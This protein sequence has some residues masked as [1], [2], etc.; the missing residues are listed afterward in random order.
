MRE[1]FENYLTEYD[2]PNEAKEVFLNAYD[3][4]VAN[5]RA[6]ALLQKTI[7][8]YEKDYNVDFDLVYNEYY[9]IIYQE[10]GIHPNTVGVIFAVCLSKQCKKYYQER[11]YSEEMFNC[12]LAD[13]KYKVLENSPVNK[14]WGWSNDIWLN[15]FYKFKR[16]GI[17]QLQFNLVD[18]SEE[19]HKNGIDLY[20]NSQVI[21]VHLPMTGQK[22]NVDE[23]PKWLK[24]AGEFFKQFLPKGPIVFHCLSWLLYSGHLSVLKPT[25]Q[26]L[27]FRNMFEIL[28]EKHY[29]D[30]TELKR[31]FHTT[32]FSDLG[33]L[34]NQTS[35]QKHYLEVLQKGEKTGS[36]W[37]ILIYQK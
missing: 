32:D 35:L 20:P 24:Q 29:D 1:Y 10:C 11:G 6:N 18:F 8:D 25:S 17:G 28:G 12:V 19:Y 22:L 14:V 2:F 27:K 36:A 4:V 26:I 34:P 16:F 15:V 23:V 3:S 21:T 30:Y 37:G 13:I 5:E 9:K 7:E 33:K 31:L